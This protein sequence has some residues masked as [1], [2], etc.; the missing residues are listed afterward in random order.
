[1]LAPWAKENLETSK[2]P[3]LKEIQEAE[4]RQTA[5]Q[6]EIAATARR[7]L[8]EQ[9][10]QNQVQTNIPTA[11]LPSTANWASSPSP[12]TPTS[13][14]P[15]A[16]AKPLAGKPAVAA[17]ASTAKKTLAQI[18]KEE[19]ARK[20]RAAAAAAANAANNLAGIPTLA[21]GKRYADLA[22]KVAS[23]VTSGLTGAWT[24]VGAGGKLKTPVGLSAATPSVPKALSGG[25][26]ISAAAAVK[27]KPVAAP[28]RSN[29]AGG[30]AS[31]Q[32]ANDELY[33]WAKGALGKG[34]NVSINGKFYAFLSSSELSNVL[35][36]DDFVRNLLQLP[37]EPEILSE[38]VYANSPT[39]DGRRFA[40]EFIR[41]RKLADK[42]IIPEASSN[43]SFVAG[44]TSESKNSGG[45]SEV[46]K[47][48]PASGGKE[49]PASA[50]KV[51]SAKKKGKR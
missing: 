36:V 48:G 42:G 35:I 12:A 11:G 8:A 44:S 29:T 1:V 39:L 37:S 17:P 31:A 5:Q 14:G 23:P 33:K 19:E 51:V 22:G 34:L 7:A 15:S 25:S 9:G 20:N 30:N 45:W 24:T 3:S 40:D 28:V 43:P 32:S 18:Q 16:W 41:R 47:K 10:R 4:A 6:E 49:E 13:G 50:F 46:A 27:A 2:G 38:A 26:V 21:G